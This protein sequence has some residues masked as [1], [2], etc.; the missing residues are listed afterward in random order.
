MANKTLVVAG[1]LLLASSSLAAVAMYN[2]GEECPAP[3]AAIPLIAVVPTDSCFAFGDALQQWAKVSCGADETLTVTTW[4]DSQCVN[5][6][7]VPSASTTFVPDQCVD[8]SPLADALVNN[9]N[10]PKTFGYANCV[11][12][13]QLPKPIAAAKGLLVSGG[14]AC[15]AHG[16][17]LPPSAFATAFA[18]PCWKRHLPVNL[19]SRHI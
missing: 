15:N 1:C 14:G 17:T 10:S 13:I 9:T 4:A 6:S 5:P 3:G 12:P 16:S 7:G 11:S 19:S 8:L 2:P 18:I